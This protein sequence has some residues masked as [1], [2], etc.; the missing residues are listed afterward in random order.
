MK[1]Y[2]FQATHP[3]AGAAQRVLSPPYDV[4]STAEARALA[5]GNEDSFLHV[6]RPEI[7][8]A[9]DIDPYSPQVYQRGGAALAALLSRGVLVEDD[10]PALWIYRLTREGRAQTGVV[11]TAAVADYVEGRIKRHEF[12]RKNKEDD[13]T[14]HI[15]GLGAQT[16]PVFLACR[17]AGGLSEAIAGAVTGTPDVNVVDHLG[18]RHEL[19]RVGEGSAAAAALE[20]GFAPL[21]AFYIADGHHRAASAARVAA[22]RPDDPRASRFLTVVFPAAELCILAYHRVAHDL[23]GLTSEAFLAKLGERFDVS[24]PGASPSPD[25]RHA[26]GLY[27]D[28]HWRTLTA[29]RGTIDEADV[30]A[31]LDVAVLQDTVLGPI[32][33]IEDPRTDPR[34]SFVGGS[35]GT[36]E[37]SARVDARGEGCAFAMFPTS[38]EELF[39]VSDQG[40]VMP[41]K[42]TWFVPKLGSG[43]FVHRLSS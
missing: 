34:V 15:E 23:N 40:H 32:L 16:G 25:A 12:T 41:P 20:A 13:R 26:F 8:L 7:D 30:V 31:R 2:P 14:Q 27:L 17:D 24:A 37:L 18:V 43:L 22:L 1:L 3:A 38:I 5:A 9:D 28:G 33:G 6:I 29:K 39:D 4:V 42:S 10:E 35:R 11:G 36:E 21:D 19:W